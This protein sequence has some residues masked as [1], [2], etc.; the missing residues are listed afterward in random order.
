MTSYFGIADAYKSAR[1][2][3][4]LKDWSLSDVFDNYQNNSQKLVSLYKDLEDEFEDIDSLEPGIELAESMVDIF[5]LTEATGNLSQWNAAM[6]EA[7]DRYV[8]SS[9]ELAN[10]IEVDKLQDDKDDINESI[11]EILDDDIINAIDSS[12]FI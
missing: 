2:E 12:D 7:V 9:S 8:E 11:D 1:S 3:I 5:K 10:E 4:L 6:T